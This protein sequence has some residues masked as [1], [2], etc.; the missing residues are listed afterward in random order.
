MSG[1]K[2]N[3]GRFSLLFVLCY[4]CLAAGAAIERREFGDVIYATI[5]A[6]VAGAALGSYL[7][8]EGE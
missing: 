4:M 6:T 2:T 5:V 1:T 7:Y 8:K 3:F